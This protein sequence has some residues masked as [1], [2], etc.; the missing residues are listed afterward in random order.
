MSLYPFLA[1]TS[2]LGLL[3]SHIAPGALWT[4]GTANAY[5]G[6][7]VSGVQTARH[8]QSRLSQIQPM[9]VRSHSPRVFRDART[10]MLIVGHACAFREQLADGAHLASRRWCPPLLRE[11]SRCIPL[12]FRSVHQLL[13]TAAAASVFLRQPV[14][15]V[16]EQGHTRCFHHPA[17][18]NSH[19]KLSAAQPTS[20][21]VEL[22][23]VYL[24]IPANGVQVGSKR[25]PWQP[26]HR[27]RC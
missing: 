26:L 13:L 22:A 11:T 27:P 7:L 6:P 15:G 3:K 19:R 4:A 25:I 21:T 8:H 24:K 18:R 17:A 2:Q 23:T 5:P 9:Q 14:S 16:R 12:S 20:L 10:A 1:E